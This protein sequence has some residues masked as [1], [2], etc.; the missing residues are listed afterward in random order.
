M[1]K[2]QKEADRGLREAI[3]KGGG[4]AY[5]LSRQEWQEPVEQYE[6]ELLKSMRK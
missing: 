6:S 1:N 4:D 3:R 5:K 2:F